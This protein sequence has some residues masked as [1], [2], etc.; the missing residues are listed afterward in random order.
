MRGLSRWGRCHEKKSQIQI[1][2]AKLALPIPALLEVSCLLNK[3][4]TWSSLRVVINIHH[5]WNTNLCPPCSVL[6]L[7][8]SAF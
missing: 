3:Q 1:P 8:S 4:G 6:Q 5:N 2:V 7:L